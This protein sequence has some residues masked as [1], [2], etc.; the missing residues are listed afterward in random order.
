[1]PISDTFISFQN[2]FTALHARLSNYPC[3]RVEVGNHYRTQHIS[4]WRLSI[5]G[6]NMI[7]S[8]FTAPMVGNRG[9]SLT[10]FPSENSCF[11][12][13]EVTCFGSNPSSNSFAVTSCSVGSRPSCLR[14]RTLAQTLRPHSLANTFLTHELWN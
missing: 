12:S 5:S 2:I 13:S 1:M 14:A 7:I 11:I 9:Y 3:R 8:L 4:L 10:T 6:K